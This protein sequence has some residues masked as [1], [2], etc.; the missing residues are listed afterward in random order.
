MRGLPSRKL[1]GISGRHDRRYCYLYHQFTDTETVFSKGFSQFFGPIDAIGSRWLLN[2]VMEHLLD[3]CSMRFFAIR[4]KSSQFPG[5]GK[6]HEF[7]GAS[8]IATGS[9][10]WFVFFHLAISAYRI[11]ILQTKTEGIH[12]PVADNARGGFGLER[13]AFAGGEIRMQVRRQRCE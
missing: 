6:F 10:D 12:R 5:T 9:I 1:F 3:E 11:V 4:K 2:Q 13:H 7:T 8:F